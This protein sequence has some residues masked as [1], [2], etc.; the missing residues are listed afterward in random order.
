[1]VQSPVKTLTLEEFLAQPET[2]P[3]SEFIDGQIIQKPMPG[4]Q[5]SHIQGKLAIAITNKLKP[6]K[7]GYAFLELICCFAGYAIV[8]DI[9]VFKW[10]NIPREK[11]G[12]IANDFLRAPDWLIEVLS[13]EQS[14]TKIIQ[15]I[16]HS[17]EYDTELAW[18]I[19]P[20]EDIVIVYFPDRP[21][22]IFIDDNALLPTPNFVEDLN[23]TA[24]EIFGW[25]T[26]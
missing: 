5:H 19:D 10:A 4:G 15:K 6:E 8:P 2:K 14:H 11:N 25:L 3:A 13:P 1:M 23:L 26:L 18:L 21:P 7:R 12:R 9:A 22:V 20:E 24:A 17:F 16:L